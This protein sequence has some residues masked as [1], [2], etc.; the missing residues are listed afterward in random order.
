MIAV[1]FEV[2]PKPGRTEEY[3]SLA[4]DLRPLLDKIDGFISVERFESL[5]EPGK[6]LSLSFFRDEK[7]IDAWRNT[8]SH[9]RV[10]RRGREEHLRELPAA[11]RRRDQGLWDAR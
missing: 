3:L 8:E 10:Q 6:I 5:T 7:A 9:R 4:A 2:R 1:I 11:H